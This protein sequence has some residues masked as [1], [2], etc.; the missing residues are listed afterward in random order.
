V[1]GKT[2]EIRGQ[3][4]ISLKLDGHEFKHPIYVCSLPINAEGLIG[5]DFMTKTGANLDIGKGK[6]S[7]AGIS[8][9]QKL[10][11][12]SPSRQTA[13]TVITSEK[14]GH[15]PSPR[16]QATK[17]EVGKVS[18]STSSWLIKSVEDTII[19]PRC[20]QIVMGKLDAT[21]GEN[22]PPVVCVESAMFP[23]HGIHPA[24]VLTRVQARSGIQQTSLQGRIVREA[25]RNC[26]YVMITNFSDEALQVPKATVLGIA[27]EVS[28]SVVDKINTVGQSCVNTPGETSNGGRKKEL[29]RKLLKG[30]LEHLP[31]RERQLI[32]PVLVKYAHVFHDEE[33]NDC[34]AT[35]EVEFE[36][37]VGDSTPIRRPL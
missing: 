20:R 23:I 22:L 31:H 26:A 10:V 9:G 3:Q 32:E 19:E 29:Y 21:K 7:V 25:A 35:N 28:E 6:I 24:R 1:T 27:E 13:L 30:K 37:P 12:S 2:L 8:K 17:E 18:G 15:S 14:K 11:S 34:K 4:I 16:Q 5:L 36:I 33:L